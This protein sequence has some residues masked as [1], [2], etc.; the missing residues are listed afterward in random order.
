[1]ILGRMMSYFLPATSTGVATK[2]KL[3]MKETHLSGRRATFGLIAV[4]LVLTVCS[5]GATA[6][7][8]QTSLLASEAVYYS[9]SG[10]LLRCH[11]LAASLPATSFG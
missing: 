3:L 1:M 11:D 7:V 6:L 10:G 8:R 5:I 4:L 9:H 2:V